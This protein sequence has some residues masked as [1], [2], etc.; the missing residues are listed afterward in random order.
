LKLLRRLSHAP[1]GTVCIAL[2][3]VVYSPPASRL[4]AQQFT[5]PLSSTQVGGEAVGSAHL[6]PTASPFGVS[7]TPDGRQEYSIAFVIT[8]LPVPSSIGPYSVYVAWASTPYFE[9]TRKL[10]TVANGQTA[11]GVVKWNKFRIIITAE[12]SAAVESRTGPIILRGS[13][14]TF[15]LRPLDA[16]HIGLSGPC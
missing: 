7:V 14:P 11:G 3:L 2:V 12:K 10:G 8:G 9:E 6:R 4:A 13:A 16:C 5:I 15:L 1:L